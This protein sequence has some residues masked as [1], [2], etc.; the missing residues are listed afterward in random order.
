MWCAAY[1]H[2]HG[3]QRGPGNSLRSGGRDWQPG[4][5][6]HAHQAPGAGRGGA[7]A[8]DRPA[9]LGVSRE[10]ARGSPAAWAVR[11]HGARV[12]GED[13]A[14]RRGAAADSD[15]QQLGLTA[16]GDGSVRAGAAGAEQRQ[17][18]GNLSRGRPAPATKPVGLGR[19]EPAAQRG[20]RAVRVGRQRG[21]RAGHHPRGHGT[22]AEGRGAHRAGVQRLRAEDAQAAGG[23]DAG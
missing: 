18:G 20:F 11:H 17:P 22:A 21:Q 2:F 6:V 5:L 13:R 7:A 19:W 10:P 9:E 3:P 12:Q 4:A 1:A 8:R 15:A 23:Q 14:A 16:T